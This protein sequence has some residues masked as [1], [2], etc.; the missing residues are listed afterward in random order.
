MD[1]IASVNCGIAGLK[2]CHHV[3]GIFC[4]DDAGR[5]YGG[6]HQISWLLG[7]NGSVSLSITYLQPIL[8]LLQTKVS[9]SHLLRRCLV[10]QLERECYLLAVKLWSAST[11]FKTIGAVLDYF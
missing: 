7:R 4:Y 5:Q 2:G 3:M 10:D 9:M 11:Y 6:P 1:R 8:L